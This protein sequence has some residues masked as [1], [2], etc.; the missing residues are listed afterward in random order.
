MRGGGSVLE[1]RAKGGTNAVEPDWTGQVFLVQALV[2]FKT[3]QQ[4]HVM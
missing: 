4:Q 2:A 3:V 1:G